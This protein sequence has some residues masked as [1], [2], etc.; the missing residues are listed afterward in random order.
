MSSMCTSKQWALPYCA[1]RVIDWIG[2]FSGTL[3][4]LLAHPVIK[5]IWLLLTSMDT[6]ECVIFDLNL[7]KA[8][9]S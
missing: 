8:D 7:D 3:E 2:V 5:I 4:L 9:C 6:V 1:L